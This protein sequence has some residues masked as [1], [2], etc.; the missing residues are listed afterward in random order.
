VLPAYDEFPPNTAV[1]LLLPAGNLEV[2]NV[3]P[4]QRCATYRDRPVIELIPCMSKPPR[5]NA[6]DSN[7]AFAHL[8]EINAKAGKTEPHL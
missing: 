3:A 7:I 8:Q 6:P 2:V 4:L 5:W 1:I